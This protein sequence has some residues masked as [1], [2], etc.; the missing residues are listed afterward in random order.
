MRTVH[1]LRSDRRDAALACAVAR[2]S[3]RPDE[4]LHYPVRKLVNS[5]RNDGPE[6]IEPL[7]SVA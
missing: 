2:E 1:D 3:A 5:T 6:L 7:E 4:F